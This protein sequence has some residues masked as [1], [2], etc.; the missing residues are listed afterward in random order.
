MLP[1]QRLSTVDADFLS[2]LKTLLAFEAAADESI[3]RTVA[4]APPLTDDQRDALRGATGTDGERLASA[5]GLDREQ[6]LDAIRGGA[7][8]SSR[9]CGSR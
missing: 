2:R 1:I 4:E 8:G 3:E 7:A 5:V 6:T 9:P